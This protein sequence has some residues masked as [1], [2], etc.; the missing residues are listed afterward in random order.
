MLTPSKIEEAEELLEQGFMTSEVAK[1][2]CQI[3]HE[4]NEK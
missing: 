3:R 1:R 2:F 4:K